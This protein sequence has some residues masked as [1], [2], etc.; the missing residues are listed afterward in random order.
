MSQDIRNQIEKLRQVIRRH[1]HLYYAQAHPEISDTE[2]DA[3]MRT[4]IDLEKQYPQFVTEDSPTVRVG[5]GIVSGFKPFSHKQKMLSLDNTYSIDEL[6][7]WHERVVKGLGRADIHYVAEL[8]IDGLS[9]NL[10][11]QGGKLIH[12]ATRGDGQTGEDVLSNVRTIREVPLVLFSKDVP[13]F[14]EVRGEVYVPVADFKKVNQE[15]ESA[16]EEMF[17]NPRNAAAGSLKL[18]DTAEVARRRLH[19]FA[20]SLGASTGF[21]GSTQWEFLRILKDWGLPTNPHAALC[22]GIEEV[23]AYCQR[24]HQERKSLAYEIDGVVVKVNG[25]H[26]QKGLGSTQKSPRWA[27]AFKFPAQ[28]ATTEVVA[29]TMH[30]GRTGVITPTAE[31]A[32]VEC[33]GVIIRNATL[34]NFDEIKR[35][36]V[37]V[38]DRVLI[39]RAGEVIPKVVAVTH[40]AGQKAFR[41]PR[42]CPACSGTVVKEK[43]EDVAYRCINPSCP[44]QLERGLFHFASRQAMDIEGLGE[45]VVAQL[46]SL[47]LVKDFADIYKLTKDDLLRLEL[48]KEKKAA[49]LLSAI[50]GSKVRSLSRVLFALGIRHVGEKAAYVLAQHFGSMDAI[51]QATRDDFDALEEIGPVM[52]ESL[53]AYF[54]LPQTK[55]L[56]AALRR[57]GLTMTE[58]LEQK[59]KNTPLAGKI[60]VFTGEMHLFSRSE[61]ERLARQAGARAASSVSRKTDFVVAGE[62]PGSKYGLAKQLGV[63]IINEEQFKEMLA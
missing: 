30:V 15:R 16:G 52:A 37:A 45:A 54:S 50:E 40:H 6:R 46:V 38:G 5:G 35:L 36:G 62:N 22:S 28:Q 12:A 29:I 44:A 21:D 13:S 17:R 61:A 63:H 4:L 1:D 49:N 23:I 24:W 20:H 33:A 3:L 41:I 10:T 14:I 25:F 26:D 55:G 56:V 58:A 51:L 31:L 42:V 48:F 57:A 8:K 2:Y 60:V 59:K 9:A 47:G 7:Q 34:H 19:F 18:L 11:Y 43:E 53:H 27:V 32:P 39:E